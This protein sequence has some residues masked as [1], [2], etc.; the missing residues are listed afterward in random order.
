[1]IWFNIDTIYKYV[2]DSDFIVTGITAAHMLAL[3]PALPRPYTI[4]SEYLE[5][6]T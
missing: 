1:M 5:S 6:R 4:Y 2:D 3:T